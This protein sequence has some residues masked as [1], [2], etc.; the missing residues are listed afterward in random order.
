MSLVASVLESAGIVTVVMS[1]LPEVSARLRSPRTLHVPFG[2]GTPMGPA[3]APEMQA[4]VLAAALDLA[5]ST[6]A[7]PISATF[8]GEA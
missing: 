5:V 8:T 3:D 4:Q 6:E 2:L 1:T 7:V